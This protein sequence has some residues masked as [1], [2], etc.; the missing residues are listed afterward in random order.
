MKVMR[1][2]NSQQRINKINSVDQKNTGDEN[3]DLLFQ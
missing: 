3:V 1:S 2:T